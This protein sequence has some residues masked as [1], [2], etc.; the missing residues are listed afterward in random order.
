VGVGVVV[1]VIEAGLGVVDL[2]DHLKV[3]LEVE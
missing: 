1:V 2:E 3:V